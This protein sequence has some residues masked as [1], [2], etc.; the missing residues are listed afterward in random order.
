MPDREREALQR[1]AL[2]RH[3]LL[4]TGLLAGFSVVFAATHFVPEPGFWVGL[5]QAGSEA[6]IVGALADWFAVTALF[7]RPLG[8]PIPHTAIV[9]RQK[10]RVG[11]W[12]GAFIVDNFLA[13]HAIAKELKS[14]D[15]LG[16]AA[17]WLA[18]RRNADRVAARVVEALPYALGALD[19]HDMRRLVARTFS[20]RLGD[21]DLAAALGTALR[22]LVARGHHA[23]ILARA[24][25]TIRAFVTENEGSLYGAVEKRLW[26]LPRKVDKFLARRLL[27][28]I[29]EALLDLSTPGHP[30]TV[31]LEET[32]LKLATD[33]EG[34]ARLRERVNAALQR[35]IATQ[36]VQAWLSS[37]WDDARRTLLA[38]AA[39]PNSDLRRAVA[40]GIAAFGS[41]LNSDPAI[42]GKITATID[43]IISAENVDWR[44]R[45][46][47][48]IADEVR[49]WNTP[50][51]TRRVEL[52]VGAELQYI[53]IN[54]TLLGFL[55][56]VGLFLVSTLL[57]GV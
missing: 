47:R 20:G 28:V 51:F 52:W 9:P 55:I 3:R 7:R 49:G 57:H 50:E 19:D 43:R 8:L 30:T 42:A 2:R 54:G 31:R 35:M 37:L 26:F 38:E 22:T 4:A 11:D 25:P 34:D 14:L 23:T 32:L 12:L 45:V 39:A 13:S 27:D 44:T 56:G 53:R 48:F 5:L 10:D 6:A 36:E 18:D 16:R 24:L 15:L 40:D 29:Q 41:T 21:F 1:D 46:A 17:S 33:L